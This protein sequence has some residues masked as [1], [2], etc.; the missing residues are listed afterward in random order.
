MRCTAVAWG[1]LHKCV[2]CRNQTLVQHVL[3]HLVDCLIFIFHMNNYWC[4]NLSSGKVESILF[5]PPPSVSPFSSGPL[6]TCLMW[7][8]SMSNAVSSVPNSSSGLIFVKIRAE[9]GQIFSKNPGKTK[10]L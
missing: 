6:W 4:N 3:Q 8:E 10:I 9:S 2:L 5:T 1:C 7:D